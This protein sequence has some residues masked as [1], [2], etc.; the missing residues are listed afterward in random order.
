MKLFT[1]G[2]E[3]VQCFTYCWAKTELPYSENI[4]WNLGTSRVWAYNSNLTS[5]HQLFF[6]TNENIEQYVNCGIY[7]ETATHET[8]EMTLLG[9]NAISISTENIAFVYWNLVYIEAMW[10]FGAVS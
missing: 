8:F 9:I 4:N 10:Y 1:I 3:F 7:K 5:L 6:F 2:V